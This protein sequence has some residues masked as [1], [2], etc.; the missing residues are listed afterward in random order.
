MSLMIRTVFMKIKYLWSVLLLAKYQASQISCSACSTFTSARGTFAD[1]AS[2][3]HNLC[4][5]PPRLNISMDTLGSVRGCANSQSG[6]GYVRCHIIRVCR[7]EF[8]LSRYR[9]GEGGGFC[10]MRFDRYWVDG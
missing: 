3:S 5:L 2:N 10:R 1:S 9:Q 4:H 8:T 6:A 7:V